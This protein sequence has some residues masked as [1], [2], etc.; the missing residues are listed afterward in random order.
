[1]LDIGKEAWEQQLSP[2]RSVIEHVEQMQTWMVMVWPMFW[3][4]MQKAQEP[5]LYKRG[6]QVREFE[7]CE[8]CMVPLSTIISS[9]DSMAIRS[10][11]AE[12]FSQLKDKAA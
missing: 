8:K 11:R 5:Q 1:M 7:V 3:P 2:H 12:G 6:A 4:Y 10:G 9:P